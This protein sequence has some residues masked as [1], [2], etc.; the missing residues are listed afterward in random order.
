MDI[1]ELV[2]NEKFFNP[3]TGKNRK[4]Y[5]DCIL[6][7]I[8]KSK[9]LPVLYDSD[10]RNC[11]TM[12][13]KNSEYHFQ[14]ENDEETAEQEQPERS[15]STIMSYLRDCGWITP[16]EIGRNGENVANISTNCRRVIDFLRKLTEKSNEGALSNHIFSM[17]EIL[18][19]SFEEDSARA[20][21][22]YSNILIPLMDNEAELKNELLDLKDNIS[23]IMRM[24]M[25]L[26]DANSIGKYLMKDELLN[27][28][29][30][31]YFF[32]KN[33]GLIPSQLAF[34]K[35]R[36]RML[37]TGEMFPKIVEECAVKMQIN[38]Q[39]AAEKVEAYISEL[40]YFIAV[41]YEENMEL[42]DARINTYY[43]L[44]NTR[45]MLVLSEGVNLEAA[46]DSFLNTMK[47]MDTDEKQAA[48]KKLSGCM[49]ISSQKY[50][51]RKS[52]EKRKRKE[53]DDTTIGLDVC[54][55]SEAEREKL[56]QEMMDNTR[57]R[58]SVGCVN[59]YLGNR[60]KYSKELELKGQMVEKK[61]DA[62]MYAAAVMYSGIEEFPYEVELQ[63]DFVETEVA[64]ISNMK[65]RKK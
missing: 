29:F 22:P 2:K 36:L 33:N 52:Y 34:I 9:E 1:F 14:S 47:G 61:E 18:K 45:I 19:A 64:R 48:L 16:R 44:A 4:I 26:Q 50:I 65:I 12:Y 35:S 43:N 41:E 54:E 56:T 49:R 55:L 37:R 58:F 23:N 53:R 24:V 3:L 7:L 40:Q 46:L 62:L 13:L 51:A 31:D 38:E 15:A 27:Q 6:V 25:E 30:N 17:Y 42:I 10:A 28:F 39:E 11:I 21:R 57:N 60:L 63:E 32:I 20:E 5:F 8:E 59:E